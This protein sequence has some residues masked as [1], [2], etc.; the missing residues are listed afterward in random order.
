M[1]IY[2]LINHFASV[3]SITLTSIA[4]IALVNTARDLIWVYDKWLI[5]ICKLL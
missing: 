5:V 3:Y 4:Y 1:S 2:W